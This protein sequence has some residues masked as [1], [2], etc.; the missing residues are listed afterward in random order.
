MAAQYYPRVVDRE[1][2]QRLTSAGAVLIEGPKAC[3]KTETARQIARSEVRFDVDASAR[4]LASASPET[5]F[6]QETPILFDEWQMVPELWNLVRREV[7][8]RSPQRGQFLL[9]G[10]ATPSDN[11]RRHSGAGRIATLR[12]RPM[13][14]FETGHSTG[15]VSL[16]KLF[17]GETPASLEVAMKLPQLIERIVIGGW[18]T[19]LDADARDAQRWLRDYLTNLVEVDVQSLDG[20]RHPANVRRLLSALGR[21]VGTQVS[22]QSLARDVGGADGPIDRQTVDS[23]LKTLNRLMVIEDVPAWSPH[24]RSS[25]PLR[26]AATRFM[27]DPSLGV[28]A[29]GVGA[30]QLLQDL[31]ATGYHFEALVVRDLRVYAQSLDGEL[32]HWRDNNGHEVDIIV[33]LADGRW[34]AIEVKLSPGSVDEAAASLLRFADKVDTRRIG[35]PAFLGV[36]TT[37]TAAYRRH[38]GVLVMPIACLGP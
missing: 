21:N 10:S 7:D 28:A 33:T 12:M 25:T 23:Y 4:A 30:D 15:A 5:L 35:P 1:L 22:V 2:R 37:R 27:V 16:Q 13:S 3:G 31:N 20:R 36:I 26:K 18:P 11:P 32:S 24:M 34:G 6:A 38:D 8:Y 19:L 9:T 17:D 29:L 14:L